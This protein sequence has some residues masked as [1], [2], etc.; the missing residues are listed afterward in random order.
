MKNHLY[1]TFIAVLFHNVSISF[2]QRSAQLAID[3]L[4]NAYRLIKIKDRPANARTAD[5]NIVQTVTPYS[6]RPES[7]I[8]IHLN[9]GLDLDINNVSTIDFNLSPDCGENCNAQSFADSWLSSK[10][11]NKT[12][13]TVDFVMGGMLPGK[14]YRLR[15]FIFGLEGMPC[16]GT[17]LPIIT[18]STHPAGFSQKKMLLVINRE[19]ESTAS[20]QNKLDQYISDV[21]SATANLIVQKYYIDNNST[22]KIGLYEYIRQHFLTDNISYL[23]FIGDNASTYSFRYLLDDLGNV[24]NSS[25]TI[26][27]QQYTHPLYQHYTYDPAY[28]YLQSW[29]YQNTCFDAPEEVRDA[30]FQQRNSLMSVGMVIPASNLTPETKAEYLVNYFEKLHRYRRKE[31]TF[32]KSVLLS[33]GFANEQNAVAMAEANGRWQSV[34]TLSFGRPKDRDYSGED[35][36][37]KGDFLNKLENN[38]YEILSLNLHGAPDYQSFGVY[39]QDINNLTKLNTQL[40]SLSSCNIGNYKAYSYLGGEY[41]GKGNVMNVHAYSDFL[42]LFTSDDDS[43]LEY[44]YRTNGAFPLMA[45]GHTVS[46]AYRYAAGY[47]ESEVILGDPLVKFQDAVPLPAVL[48]NFTAIKEGQAAQLNW[49]TTSENGSA[50]FQIERSTSGT[51]WKVLGKVMAGGASGSNSIYR[52]LDIFPQAGE[53]LYRLKLVDGDGSFAYS[54]LRRLIFEKSFFVY[55]NPVSDRI[56]FSPALRDRAISVTITDKS[57]NMLLQTSNIPNEGISV[58]SIASG[59]YVLTIFYDDGSAEVNKLVITR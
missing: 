21:Q 47:A 32:N 58:K 44:E 36:V 37:W 45:A 8:N 38:S 53:N 57:G 18:F 23:F 16:T 2:A 33:D 43:G 1:F 14:S 26:T 40:I 51:D 59:L 6:V 50:Y 17:E 25:G 11:V 54:Q 20:V 24:A 5:F 49:S 29:K 27:F 39:K 34:E 7:M 55:P 30:V 12:A 35:P 4:T 52:F 28:Y 56:L 31:V 22:D 19:W 46:D 3:P 48:A 10:A 15:T 9:F 42:F 13:R 41:L